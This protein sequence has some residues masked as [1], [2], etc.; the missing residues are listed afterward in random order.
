VFLFIPGLAILIRLLLFWFRK[1]IVWVVL[2]VYPAYSCKGLT[3]GKE[4][5]KRQQLKGIDQLKYELYDTI[6]SL[7]QKVSCMEN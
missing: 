2:S 4:Q 5:V 7:S 6:K 3:Q 1:R